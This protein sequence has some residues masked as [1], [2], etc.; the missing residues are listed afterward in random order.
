MDETFR[1][2]LRL[3][4]MLREYDPTRLVDYREWA[5]AYPPNYDRSLDAYLSYSLLHMPWAVTD[6]RALIAITGGTN[7]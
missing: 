4:V 7:I 2:N 3:M 6:V 1:A 5:D